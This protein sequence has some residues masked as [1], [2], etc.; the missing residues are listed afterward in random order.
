MDNKP[1]VREY[2]KKGILLIVLVMTV[3]YLLLRGQNLREIFGAILGADFRFILI[4][5][6]CMCV[7]LSCE[8]LNLRR[9]VH[10][11]GH[12]NVTVAGSARYAFSGF[13]GSAITPFASGGQPLQA[14]YMYQ[15]GV[16]LAHSTLA[17]LVQLACYHTVSVVA[18]LA[19]F[20]GFHAQLTRALGANR[21]LL[22]AG[23]M[24]NAL[25]LVF[26][27]VAIFSKKLAPCVVHGVLRLMARIGVRNTD[28]MWKKSGCTA[29]GLC[30]QCENF[31]DP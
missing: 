12:R 26:Y 2:I 6:L 31:Q 3:F 16:P 27:L 19:A 29:E 25:L 14:Y 4:G 8:A 30:R 10:M 1:T 20:I 13:F 21:Y 5:M 15:D 17:L 11:M 24:V 18:A 23:V 9:A 22:L 7:Y 28:A